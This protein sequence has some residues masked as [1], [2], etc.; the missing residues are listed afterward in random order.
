MCHRLHWYT[1]AVCVVQQ[2][3]I[4]LIHFLSSLK[5][6]NKF[7]SSHYG[8]M[9]HLMSWL[10]TSFF[11]IYFYWAVIDIVCKFKVYI[12][13]IYILQY[14][15]TTALAN[16]CIMSFFCF[17]F[18]VLVWWDQLRSSLCSNFEFCCLES[19]CCTLNIQDCLS[20]DRKCRP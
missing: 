2:F 9:D 6:Y 15:T 4:S 3:N 12:W 16:I 13:Y 7:G 5:F 20:P 18:F 19:L 14:I 17:L 10:D 11:K 1:F 8:I